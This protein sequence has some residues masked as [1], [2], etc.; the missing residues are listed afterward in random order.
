LREYLARAVSRATGAHSAP[1]VMPNRAPVFPPAQTEAAPASL[2]AQGEVIFRHAAA[3]A[4]VAPA[5]PPSANRSVEASRAT[6]IPVAPQRGSEAASSATVSLERETP[7][8]SAAQ[9]RPARTFREPEE[10]PAKI[11]QNRPAERP[12]A[13]PVVPRP[14]LPAAQA[15]VQNAVATVVRAIETPSHRAE[16]S[17]RSSMNDQIVP[18]EITPRQVTSQ[19]IEPRNRQ[20]RDEPRETIQVTPGQVAPR[21]ASVREEARNAT[22]DTSVQVHIGRVEV[23]VAAPA[24]APPAARSRGPRGFA[25]YEAVR[26]YIT[27]NRV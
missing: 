14:A 19:K 15:A 12:T 16:S 6:A 21:E 11:V 17:P 7:A 1:P 10:V 23:R 8:P 4:N 27:R 25:E 9:F 26:R 24:P 3:K 18:Q 5:I 22:E 13:R 2:Q 20:E